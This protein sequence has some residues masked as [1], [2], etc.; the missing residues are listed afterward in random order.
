VGALECGVEGCHRAT[1]EG[2]PYCYEHVERHPYVQELLLKLGAMDDEVEQVRK[3][4]ARVENAWGPLACEVVVKLRE[5]GGSATCERL[6]RDLQRDPDVV[7]ALLWMLRRVG[8]L[9]LT[10]TERGA[11]VATLT[12]AELAA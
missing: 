2:K 5:R 10:K 8:R 6:S 3:R 1:R 11:T 9:V 12:L 4:G 7:R